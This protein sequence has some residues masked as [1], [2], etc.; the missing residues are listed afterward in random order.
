MHCVWGGEACSLGRAAQ[1]SPPAPHPPR[2]RRTHPLP[3]ASA[4]GAPTASSAGCTSLKTT[5]PSTASQSSPTT[6]RRT[7][8]RVSLHFV[9]AALLVSA[10]LG[11]ALLRL[12]GRRVPRAVGGTGQAPAAAPLHSTPCPTH[13]NPPA[14]PLPCF[15]QTTRSCPRCAWRTAATPRRKQQRRGRA[16]T[17]PSCLR[18]GATALGI[19]GFV[20]LRCCRH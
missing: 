10:F 5:A 18:Q 9:M 12:R 19:S 6:R 16:L 17:G 11:S 3:Q 14:L 1:G 8:P 20:A 7:A 4:A 13:T 15:R 2:P